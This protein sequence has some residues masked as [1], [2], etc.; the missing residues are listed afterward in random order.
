M[1]TQHR[2]ATI[3]EYA[4][5]TLATLI[6]EDYLKF[7]GT[8]L[9]Y[10]LAAMLDSQ[11]EIKELATELVMK[12]TLEKND[13]FMRTCLLECPF[14]FNAAPCFGQTMSSVSK[15]GHILKGDDKEPARQ[16]IYRYLLRKVDAVHLYMYLGNVTRLLDHMEKEKALLDLPDVQSSIADFLY[17]CT[18]VCIANEK[19]KKNLTKAAKENQNG[20]DVLEDNEPLTIAANEPES[21]EG[22]KGRGRG[23][24]NL[25][26]IQQALS[27][28]EKTIPLIASVAEKL[29]TKNATKFNPVIDRLCTEMCSHFE[30]LMDYAQPR[31]FWSKYSKADKRTANASTSRTAN[32]SNTTAAKATNESASA[33][34]KESLRTK[35]T[36]E[37]DSGR[38]TMEDD[39]MSTRSRTS[40]AKSTKTQSQSSQPSRSRR[41]NSDADSCVSD[42]SD[43]ESVN[44]SRTNRSN[45]S[46]STKNKKLK[47]HR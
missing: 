35:R 17:V 39:T 42:T 32:K 44:S 40:P 22:G 33:S 21:A 8:L 37:N 9:I 23:K 41:K 6:L 4:L 45:R 34:R 38:F 12:Y 1:K 27:I 3:R 16:Y 13:I 10:V 19:F 29:R 15:S 14:V 11:R 31:D 43:S 5:K 18:E 24:K 25:P 7:R 30:S 26:T 47:R 46:K 20:E 36:E 2:F 28:V